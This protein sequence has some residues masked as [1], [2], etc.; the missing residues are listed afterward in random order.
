MLIHTAVPPRRNNHLHT[1]EVFFKYVTLLCCCQVSHHPPISVCYAESRNFIFS[2]DARIKTKFWGKSMEFQ[3]T[4]NYCCAFQ[5]ILMD[6]FGNEFGHIRAFI[7]AGRLT[8]AI[9][10]QA[11]E[12][13]IWIWSLL[14][15]EVFIFALVS[16]RASC[17]KLLFPWAKNDWYIQQMTYFQ[18]SAEG[19]RLFPI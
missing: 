10:L 11:D 2:Q 8:I 16:R 3:P 15:V 5:K 7:G 17:S 19:Y 9:R 14:G 1:A 12:H 6:I 13:R 4:G 18:F